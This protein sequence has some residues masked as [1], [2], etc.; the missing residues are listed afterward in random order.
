MSE[1]HSWLAYVGC[2]TTR[3]R[4][5]QGR[6]IRVF[7]VREG[8][9][10]EEVQLLEGLRN[11]SYLCLHPTKPV[12]YTVHGDFEEVSSYLIQDSGRL[13]KRQEVDACGRN[14]VHLAFSPSGRW[15]LVAN[16]AS[17][18]IV[19]IPVDDGG[20][21]GHVVHSLELRGRHGP[22]PEQD[23]S[24]PHQVC[25]SPD[26]R[27]AFV[28]DKGLDNVFALVLD[29]STGRLTVAKESA[30]APGSGPRHM[31]F[32]PSR[33]LAY[34]VGELDRTIN[35]FEYERASLGSHSS[36][37]TVPDGVDH[38]SAAGI[39]V[40]SD[41]QTLYVSNRGHDSVVAYRLDELGNPQ[42]PH[43]LAAGR[44]P[45]FISRSPFGAGLVV[46]CEDGHSIATFSAPPGTA[47]GFIDVAQTG[48]PVCVVF[49]KVHS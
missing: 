21:L 4:N 35:I 43:W 39:V 9:E 28:P 20:V 25:F 12:L 18:N 29:E 37:S 33:P 23:A 27:F 13:G 48:S 14:P 1:P 34:V 16:Y 5:A 30:M 11:P 40:S 8:F 17:G 46:A 31:V 3:E 22:H 42:A 24:H 47:G 2:R 44:T 45:R 7:A 15:L 49:R 26:G 6:G 36:M 41:N 10:W 19:S 38:G 32:H